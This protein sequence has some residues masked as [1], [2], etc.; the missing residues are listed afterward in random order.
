MET[1][2]Q[3]Y[4]VVESRTGVWLENQNI[5]YLSDKSGVMQVWK[6]SI[7]DK[8]PI[9]MTFFPEPVRCLEAAANHR[10]LLFT[11]DLGGNEQEQLFLLKAGETVAL[12][13][14]G[15]TR[16]QL[17][18]TNA[19]SSMVYF[20]CNRRSKANFDV[21]KMDMKTRQIV[22]VMESQD[23]LNIPAGV[24]PDGRYLLCNKL[25]GMSDNRLHLVD[26]QTGESRD[27]HPQGTFAQYGSPAWKSD[28][29]GFY[30]TC[31]E[32]D[33]FLYV[34]YYDVA[35]E[36][37]S[38]VYHTDHDVTR[39][40]LSSDDRYLAMVVSTDG[41][42]TFRVLDTYTGTFVQIPPAPR[43]FLYTYAGMQWSPEGHQLLFTF[44]SG[45]HPTG[46]WVL[47]LD[48]NRVYAL[49]DSGLPASIREKLVE[50]E[51]GEY[52]SFDG[53]RI[54]YLIYKGSSDPDSPTVLHIHGGPEGQA[55]PM[56]DPLIQYLAGKGFNIAA[57]NIRGS[58]GYGKTFH[59]LDDVEK[60]MDSIRDI[61]CLARHLMD[62]G[63]VQPG[64]LGIMGASYGGYA[65]LCA[66]SEYPEMWS[67]GVDIVGMSNLETF[68]ENTA[69]YRRAHREQEYGSLEFHRAVLR[70]SSPIHQ[71]H[72]ICAP[73]MVI[74]GANDPRVPVSEAEQIVENL[75]KRSIPVKYLCYPDE[76]HGIMKLANKLD[77][78]PQVVRFLKQH[79]HRSAES[80]KTEYEAGQ[81]PCLNNGK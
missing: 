48:E 78:Y 67:A 62:T 16:F 8:K 37:C 56:Y 72:R 9:Q 66:L 61:A 34:G 17:A 79:L 10:D 11:I 51:L 81:I 15:T 73:L 33:E 77:C 4:T 18:G 38:H 70:A 54:A 5:A 26:M 27:I 23:N 64:R 49:T 80:E 68:L 52:H 12:T 30:F 35:S 36:K 32:G 41:Y 53:L 69:P 21:C 22:T 60:R 39:V 43:G 71:A 19:D 75:K 6:M 47:D 76:G 40:A 14:D 46:L 29:S 45:S 44:S 58:I 7:Q 42:G 63:M 20:T 57:P 1:L 65:A 24:S 50:P 55:F 31:D 13:H 3:Y 25:K 74:H 2:K 28:S 59:H